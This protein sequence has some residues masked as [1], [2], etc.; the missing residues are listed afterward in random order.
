[1]WGEGKFASL[2]EFFFARHIRR[3]FDDK[4]L[5]FLILR[6]ECVY[7][8]NL[9][10]MRLIWRAQIFYTKSSILPPSLFLFSLFLQ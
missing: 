1:M 4:D 8:E 6:V 9:R 10:N 7:A 3:N 2:G 5:I